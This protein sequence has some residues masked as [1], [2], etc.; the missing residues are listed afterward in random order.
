MPPDTAPTLGVGHNS[1]SLTPALPTPA[2]RPP[3]IS[4]PGNSGHARTELAVARQ[5]KMDPTAFRAQLL[6]NFRVR[7]CPGELGAIFT[8][9]DKDK[10]MLIDG[11]EVLDLPRD[12]SACYCC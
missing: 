10:S 11:T 5:M 6:Q 1:S 12:A 9:F 2:P 8:T 7:L 3:P 4:S